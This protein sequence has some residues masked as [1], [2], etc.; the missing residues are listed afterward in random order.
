M[1]SKKT[2]DVHVL[3]DIPPRQLE[4]ATIEEHVSISSQT[5]LKRY[6]G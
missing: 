6:G 4:E 3:E 5:R 1:E 2:G